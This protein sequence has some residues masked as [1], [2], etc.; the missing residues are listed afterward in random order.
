MSF[1]FAYSCIIFNG[2]DILEFIKLV[3]HLDS[4]Q[5]AGIILKN[6]SN[7]HL[8]FSS[9]CMWVGVSVKIFLTYQK[10]KHL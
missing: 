5:S 1:C 3:T 4:F 9:F 2:A 10:E 8:I 7:K 6:A